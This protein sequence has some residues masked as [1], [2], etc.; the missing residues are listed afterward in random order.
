M[1]ALCLA[2]LSAP[3]VAG[4][5][6]TR[7][8][9]TPTSLRSRIGVE[10]AAALTAS[11]AVG[12]RLRGLER[13][14]AAGTPSAVGRLV[15]AIEPGGSATTAEERLT[16]VR[17]LAAFTRDADVRRALARAMGGHA[18]PSAPGAP[19]PLDVLAEETAALALAHSGAPDALGALGKALVLPGRASHAAHVALVAHPPKRLD[20][21]LGAGTAPTLELASLLSDLADPR[22]A[23]ALRSLV[24]RG[25]PDVRAVAAVALAHLGDAEAAPLARRWRDPKAPAVLRIAAARILTATHAKDG[26]AAIA[27]LIDD[28]ETA[29]DGIALAL[30]APDPSLVLPLSRRLGSVRAGQARD[31][32]AA[33]GR[34]GGAGGASFLASLLG[35][36]EKGPDAADALARMP[37]ANAAKALRDAFAFPRARR[38]AARAGAVRW[39]VLGDK[40]DGLPA[41]LAALGASIDR[42]DR[43]VGLSGLVA[44]DAKRLETLMQPSNEDA[45]AS[46]APLLLLAPKL[47]ASRAAARILGSTETSRTALA[48]ALA[49]PRA[50]DE[51]PT[52]ALV[53]LIDAKGAA[54]PLAARALAARDETRLRS[55]V[56]A[57]LSSPSATLR[58]HVAL[59]LGRSAKPDATGLLDTAYRFETDPEVRTAILR[60]LVL[61]PGPPSRTL[62]LARDLDPE[63]RAR[64]NARGAPSAFQPG[65][66]VLWMTPFGAFGAPPGQATIATPEGLLY[67][68][69]LG[70][71]GQ[72][73]AAG[74]PL[75]SSVVRVAPEHEPDDDST[76]GASG[77][78]KSDRIEGD[79]RDP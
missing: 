2:L 29:S 45:T 59:G 70:P 35:D 18:T 32:L 78:E 5:E 68:I 3:D 24:L 33:I 16:A 49:V 69:V 39:L 27:L 11:D 10:A 57:L 15:R 50:E 44:L 74:L 52:A 7:G 26:A 58:A 34:A 23:D 79:R 51:V 60:A 38:A 17:M 21:V 8:A 19:T 30:D 36:K 22:S 12:D 56:T 31:V 4:E 20:L 14:G 72:A 43:T 67:P 9:V 46:L 37:G 54:S 40:I 25:T 65:S 48:F 47:V 28:T 76:R 55:T 64:Q 13:L 61:R 66:D 71:D 41:T 62:A 1:L 53:A 75:G 63:P 73:L 42:A 6:P 77:H